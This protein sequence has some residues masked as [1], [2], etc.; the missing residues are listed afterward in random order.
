MKN[1]VIAKR[2]AEGFLRA[3]K[4]TLGLEPG[5]K[6]LRNVRSILRDQPDVLRFL[7]APV[8]TR[9]EK[10]EIVNRIFNEGFL[11]LTRNFLFLL[12]NR[13]RVDL[14]NDIT[15]YV[16]QTYANG[17][18][19]EAVLQ[20]SFPLDT[21]VLETIKQKTE[22]KLNR[23]LKLYIHLDPD[24]LGGIRLTVGHQL[25]DYSLQESLGELKQRLMT[26]KVH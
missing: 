11:D 17:E 19:L 10:Y 4:E 3:A 9:A 21:E 26:V 14:L 24:L 8:L 12:I 5:I 16:R 7:I 13:S 22:N 25:F 1:K 6:E 23:R 2:Y 15:E 18:A 20:T